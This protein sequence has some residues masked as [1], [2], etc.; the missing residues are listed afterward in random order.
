MK[1]STHAIALFNVAS[2]KIMGHELLRL[3]SASFVSSVLASHKVAGTV[4]LGTGLRVAG[5]GKTAYLSVSNDKRGL[6]HTHL[7]LRFHFRRKNSAPFKDLCA[8]FNPASKIS[9]TRETFKGRNHDK[10]TDPDY[11]FIHSLSS[12]TLRSSYSR[13]SDF[14]KYSSDKDHSVFSCCTVTNR[15]LFSKTLSKTK[16]LLGILENTL[17]TAFQKRISITSNLYVTPIQRYFKG[18]LLKTAPPYPS[19]SSCT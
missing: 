2:K 16:T 13:K 1:T 11:V 10:T 6:N 17:K 19:M 18:G 12:D 15:D 3:S 9:D 14:S 7:N 4:T 5:G 8:G